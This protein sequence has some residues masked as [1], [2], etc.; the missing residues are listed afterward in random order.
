MHLDIAGRL[1]CP[2]CKGGVVPVAFRGDAHPYQVGTEEALGGGS[3]SQPEVMETGVLLC[4]SCKVWFPVYNFVPVLLVFRTPLHERFS[5]E[6]SGP[7]GQVSSYTPP[8]RA[9]RKGE[10]WVWE[11]FTAE[12]ELVDIEQDVLSF[13]YTVD[14]L[15]ALNR[16]VWLT[17]VGSWPAIQTVLDVGCGVGMEAI[18]LHRLM[19]NATIFAVDLNFALLKS[20]RKFVANRQVHL[21]VASLFDLP[22]RQSSF[23]LVYCQGVLHHTYSTQEGFSALAG[24]VRPQGHLFVWVYGLDDHLVPKGLR[25]VA[26]RTKYCIER[27]LRPIISAAP[28]CLRNALLLLLAALLHPLLRSRVRHGQAWTL[29]HTRHSVHDWLSPR[30]AHRHSYNEVVEWFEEK[31]FEPIAVQSPSA[32]RRLF[33]RR[34]FGVGVLG[35]RPPAS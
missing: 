18:A 25:G 5:T 2:L 19:P 10:R 22:F 13:T 1:C 30:Y 21:F 8:T 15:V 12:W 11:S 26:A 23:D 4:H 31:G 6:F 14:D 3:G 20:G 27:L 7:L 9:P 24:Y 33:Q 34:A 17:R 32:Y 29:R 35:R 16:D 28:L